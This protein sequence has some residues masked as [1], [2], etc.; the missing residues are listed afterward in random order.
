MGLER[1]WNDITGVRFVHIDIK[2]VLPKVG[3][4]R[5]PTPT[6]SCCL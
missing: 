3:L 2:K 1:S 6:P 4:S 5:K